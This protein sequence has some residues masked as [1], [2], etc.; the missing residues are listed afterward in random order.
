MTKLL[1]LFFTLGL[2]LAHR[3]L[4]EDMTETHVRRVG[5]AWLVGLSPDTYWTNTTEC[6]N[7]SVDTYFVE[8]GALSAAIAD[9]SR[10]SFSNAQ[11][12]ADL[13]SNSSTM[14]RYCNS[15]LNATSH[16]WANNYN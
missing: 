5:N 3:A 10:S 4:S 11:M 14:L 9:S 12:A 13:I 16:F 1:L 7:R 2:V 15:M 8:G 6:F